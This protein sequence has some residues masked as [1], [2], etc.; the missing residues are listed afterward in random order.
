MF[1]LTSAWCCLQS[2][3]DSAGEVKHAIRGTVEGTIDPACTGVTPWRD[4]A[5]GGAG[6]E[7]AG[8]SAAKAYAN[9]GSDER[10]VDPALDTVASWP[11]SSNTEDQVRVGGV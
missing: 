9:T 10:G 7:P 4:E 3:S 5:A 11:A 2:L 8:D 6:G 1:L